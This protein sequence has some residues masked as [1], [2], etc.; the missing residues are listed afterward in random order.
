M[1]VNYTAC[2]VAITVAITPDYRNPIG[3]PHLR[4]KYSCDISSVRSTLRGW[5]FDS[6]EIY[7]WIFCSSPL[8][9]K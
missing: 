3:Y 2:H 9:S 7:T 6:A 5:P 1:R 4:F 8:V